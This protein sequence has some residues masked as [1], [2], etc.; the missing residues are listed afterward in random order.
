MLKNTPFD[1]CQAIMYSGSILIWE[2]SM[3]DVW[4]QV[5]FKFVYWRKVHMHLICWWLAILT[6]ELKTCPW[7]GYPLMPSWHGLETRRWCCRISWCENRTKWVW[8]AREQEGLID[9]DGKLTHSDISNSITIGMLLF[10]SG[11]SW[12]DI[13]YACYMYYPRARIKKDSSLPEG[14]MFKRTY[15]Q[16]IISPWR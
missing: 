14:Y 3:W 1:L 16:S 9:T 12:Q 8:L 15:S 2:G 5:T 10:L 11:Y 6:N 4:I 7:F 13:A